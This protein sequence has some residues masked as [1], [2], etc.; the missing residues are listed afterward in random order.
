MGSVLTDRPGQ[1][2]PPRRVVGRV[3]R[4][5]CIKVLRREPGTS[6]RKDGQLQLG[7]LWAVWEG[8]NSFPTWPKPTWP[9]ELGQLF[10]KSLLSGCIFTWTRGTVTERTGHPALV[11]VSCGGSRGTL[12]GPLVPQ[13]FGQFRAS[14]GKVTKPVNG[15]TKSSPLGA[16]YN[17]T[18]HRG[19]GWPLPGGCCQI[20]LGVF[21]SRRQVLVAWFSYTPCCRV[22]FLRSL[23]N[24]NATGWRSK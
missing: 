23:K 3:Q 15:W 1:Q 20:R 11:S 21:H 18:Q 9:F 2:E 24:T 17:W 16:S 12:L 4:R 14:G 19:W 7:H 6:E 10:W 5:E 8:L 22:S 13:R